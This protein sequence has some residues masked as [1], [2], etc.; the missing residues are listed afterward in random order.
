MA[1]TDN[2]RK[3]HAELIE[4]VRGIEGILDPQ[5][6]V[7][8]ASKARAMLSILL[9]KLG[10]HLAMEDNSL[11][12]RLEKHQDAKLREVAKKFAG[13]MSG[14]KPAV[15]AFGRK[16]TE[17]EI[18]ANPAVFCA[19]ARKLFGILSDRIQRENT[20]FYALVDQAA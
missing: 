6:L 8:D 16:W 7:A 20:Q 2:F 12:P 5:K 17:S 18:R 9:G 11:Y 14:V 13:E 4:L 19:E 1:A 3:Q 10:L 15:D